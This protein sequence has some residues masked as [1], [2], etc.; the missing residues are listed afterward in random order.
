MTSNRAAADRVL[1]PAIATLIL[2]G[3]MIDLTFTGKKLADYF[4]GVR[5]DWEGARKIVN[6]TNRRA[7]IATYGRSYYASLSYTT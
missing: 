2:F 1:D 5:E 3:G 6:G 7:L 4:D